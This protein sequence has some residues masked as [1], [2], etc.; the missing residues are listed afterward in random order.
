MERMSMRGSEVSQEASWE[1]LNDVERAT[2]FL[3]IAREASKRVYELRDLL[4]QGTLS[5]ADIAVVSSNIERDVFAET[6]ALAGI[7]EDERFRAINPSMD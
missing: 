5:A 2:K 3:A 4:E 1:N 6:C 7:S